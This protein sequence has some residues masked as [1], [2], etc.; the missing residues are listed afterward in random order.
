MSTSTRRRRRIRPYQP[1][2]KLPPL[3]E[4]DFAALRSNIAI[5]GVKVPIRFW[6]GRRPVPWARPAKQV[7]LFN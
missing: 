6:F 5:N 1:I 2:L 7:Q 4:D 3:S